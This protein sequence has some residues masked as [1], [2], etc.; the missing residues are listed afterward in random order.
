MITAREAA[1]VAARHKLTLSDAAALSRLA[2]SPEE[3]EEL[4]SIFVDGPESKP[5]PSALINARIRER[6]GR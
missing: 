3:A 1:E 4:A 5:D 6:A 2:D